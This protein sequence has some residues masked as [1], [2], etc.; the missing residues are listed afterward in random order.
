[1]RRMRP[2]IRPAA[3][4]LQ[5]ARRGQASQETAMVTPALNRMRRCHCAARPRRR[6]LARDPSVRRATRRKAAATRPS[7]H[8]SHVTVGVCAG[9]WPRRIRAKAARAPDRGFFRPPR[10]EE[11]GERVMPRVNAGPR[12]GGVAGLW[13]CLWADGLRPR[14][15]DA[16]RRKRQRAAGCVRP[17]VDTLLPARGRHPRFFEE[18]RSRQRRRMAVRAAH[19][20]HDRDPL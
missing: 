1:M 4:D 11:H 9:R 15:P 8:H 6:S 16:D 2:C 17:L 5:R 7:G 10:S 19:H 18:A 13:E 20:P 3:Q 12:T 14:R